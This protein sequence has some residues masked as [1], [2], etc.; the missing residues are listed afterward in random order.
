MYPE[1]IGAAARAC[2]N[3]GIPHLIVVNPE[4]PDE[5]KMKAMATHVGEK[6]LENMKIFSDLS[7]ALSEFSF[8]VGTT[9][10]LGRKRLVYYTPR[11]IAPYLCELSFNN[12]IAILFG[13][14]RM[15]LS[16]EELLFCDKVITI[17][18]TENASLNVAQ[19][20][21]VV[22]Y[23]IFQQAANPV[24]PKPRLATQKELSVMYKL[25]EAT[26]E[27]IDYVP[28]ENKV[29]WMT[30]IRRFL[31]R[32]ELTAKEVK[33]IQGFCRQLLWRLGKKVNLSVQEEQESQ[34]DRSEETC[35]KEEVS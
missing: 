1:N 5:L 27:E 9:A 20:V 18:T 31:S 34:S 16:N 12:R 4:N 14:E 7:Q 13:N 2:A 30:N 25:L 26:L 33:I 17:P 15:G 32:V 29:L 22:L 8:V 3:F 23:E 11:E 28:H 19:A 35:Q 21:V 24:F 6:V 10:R